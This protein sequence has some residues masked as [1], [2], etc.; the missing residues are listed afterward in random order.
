MRADDIGVRGYEIKRWDHDR[1]EPIVFGIHKPAAGKPAKHY[2][3]D[4]LKAK[5]AV[6]AP[7]KYDVSRNFVLRQNTSMVIKAPRVTVAAE[8]EATEK[9]ARFPSPCQYQ[10]IHTRVEPKL[11]ACYGYKGE[12]N[13]FLDE[14]MMLGK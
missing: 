7:C 12:R 4:L 6:P 5:E 8:I 3:D 11:A 9:K 2:L 10:L 14:A 13:G 1:D